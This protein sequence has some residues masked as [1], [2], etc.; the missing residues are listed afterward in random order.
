MAVSRGNAKV[1]TTQELIESLQNRS[2]PPAGATPTSPARNVDDWRERAAK[3]TERV[4]LIDQK[5]N[6]GVNRLK[7]HRSGSNN[8]RESGVLHHSSPLQH[9]QRPASPD[10]EDD[11]EIIVVDDVPAAM[12][13]Q[14]RKRLP[15]DDNDAVDSQ[16]PTE[17]HLVVP[18]SL[19]EEE[20]LRRLPPIDMDGGE[21][22]HET[23]VCWC[24]MKEP[25][26]SSLVVDGSAEERPPLPPPP[27][28]FREH[29]DCPARRR[30]EEK[31]RLNDVGDERVA[32]LHAAYADN[33]NGNYG[34]ARL[35][36]EQQ[37]QQPSS[38]T[39]ATST[40]STISHTDV[41]IVPN[42]YQLPAKSEACS[43]TYK[44]YSISEGGEERGPGPGQDSTKGRQFCEF[45]EC[46]DRPSYDGETLRILPY[47]IID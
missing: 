3:L 9:L 19:S 35:Q 42:F 32:L 38:P 43:E 14:H 30:L 37:Q 15:S 12:S 11:D 17:Q 29:V 16:P 44:K 36:C 10:D 45:H 47:V 1:K 46:L 23:P 24:V 2:L 20:A 33:L 25:V 21:D 27:V 34:E 28:A 39:T 26:E 41:N 7:K 8:N 40:P 22:E 5:L 13:K 18:L 6:S 4:S 31:Y